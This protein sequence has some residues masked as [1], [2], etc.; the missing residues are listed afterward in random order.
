ME[1]SRGN[2]PSRWGS[3][4]LIIKQYSPYFLKNCR[5]LSCRQSLRAFGRGATIGSFI[6]PFVFM[7]D[8]VCL[9]ILAER[10][11][12]VRLRWCV[13]VLIGKERH[14]LCCVRRRRN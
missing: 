1:M 5:V 9:A 3:L 2:C 11:G 13:P 10:R 4:G 6:P 14:L 8:F 12:F 7:V